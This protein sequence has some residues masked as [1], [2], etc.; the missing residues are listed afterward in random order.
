MALGSVDYIVAIGKLVGLQDNNIDN[1]K[2]HGVP[3]AEGNV[4]VTILR[5]L[6]PDAKL[7]FPIKD[8]LITVQDAVNSF[9]AWPK[10][11]IVRAPPAA[12]NNKVKQL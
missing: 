6:V 3:M 7:P 8:E 1:E 12:P 9:V 5:A 10:D 2:I 11:M 4:R